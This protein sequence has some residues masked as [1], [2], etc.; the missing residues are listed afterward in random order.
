MVSRLIESPER[1]TAIVYSAVAPATTQEVQHLEQD[2]ARYYAE[3][4]EPVARPCADR[5][6]RSV[7]RL[8]DPRDVSRSPC[9]LGSSGILCSSGIRTTTLTSSVEPI[10]YV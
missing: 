5:C 4:P 9:L 7:K 8:A 2:R 10:I 6:N 1:K 3:Q